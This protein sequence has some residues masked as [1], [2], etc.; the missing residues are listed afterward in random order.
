MSHRHPSYQ[1]SSVSESTNQVA[2]DSFIVMNNLLYIFQSTI[3][4][5]HKIKTGL[6]DFVRQ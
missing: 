1:M 4:E 5:E 3:D 2:L 6:I